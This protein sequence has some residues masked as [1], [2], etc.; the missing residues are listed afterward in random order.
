MKKKLIFITII[1]ISIF[2]IY[3]AIDCYIWINSPKEIVLSNGVSVVPPGGLSPEIY[4]PWFQIVLVIQFINI[5]LQYYLLKHEKILLKDE[6]KKYIIILI[7]VFII[8]ATFFIP[9]HRE[10]TINSYY[11]IYNMEIFNL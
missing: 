5:Y 7:S 11:N 10:Y 9:S 6:R 1:L 2:N 3:K 8:V 4:S